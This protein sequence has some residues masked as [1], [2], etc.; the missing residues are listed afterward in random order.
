MHYAMSRV[1]AAN[2]LDGEARAAAEKAMNEDVANF[3][4][5]YKVVAEHARLTDTGRKL[6]DGALTYMRTAA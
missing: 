1:L 2:V 6:M 5:G 3:N 4:S